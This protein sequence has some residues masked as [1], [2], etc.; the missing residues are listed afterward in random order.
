RWLYVGVSLAAAAALLIA[1]EP[2]TKL[3]VERT[4]T[5]RRASAS[6]SEAITLVSP[7]Q[8]ETIDAGRISFAWRRYDGSTYRLVVSDATGHILFEKS[9]SDTALSIAPEIL[10]GA[11]DKLYWT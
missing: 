10:K 3:P 7:A 2:R 8:G 1:V 9:T 4:S 5:E 6:E 11:K